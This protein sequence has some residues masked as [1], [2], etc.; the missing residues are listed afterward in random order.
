M[1]PSITQAHPP[2]GASTIPIYTRNCA[3]YSNPLDAD[4]LGGAAANIK[5]ALAAEYVGAYFC[6]MCDFGY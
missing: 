6:I 3:L 2:A 4:M 5:I 1:T